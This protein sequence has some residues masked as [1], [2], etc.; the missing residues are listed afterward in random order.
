MQMVNK[1]QRPELGEHIQIKT[2]FVKY[3][4]YKEG[5]KWNVVTL[6]KPLVGIYIGWRT[7]AD[8]LVERSGWG[9]ESWLEPE[10]YNHREAWLV[11]VNERQKPF[12]IEP[13]D[14]F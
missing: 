9:D 10:P 5:N 7:I 3:R 4:S 2:K 14:D 1:K 6:D 11:V 13:F 8:C 12:Y